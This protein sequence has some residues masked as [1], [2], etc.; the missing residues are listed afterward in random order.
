MGGVAIVTW[1]AGVTVGANGV[2]GAV[3]G[4]KNGLKFI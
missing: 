4:E 1:Q 3:L 2:V